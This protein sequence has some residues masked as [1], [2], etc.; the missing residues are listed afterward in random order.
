MAVLLKQASE[1]SNP[2]AALEACAILRKE[3]ETFSE[4][5]ILDYL[6]KIEGLKDEESNCMRCL[7]LEAY[8]V[9]NPE[10][11]LKKLSVLDKNQIPSGIDL[12]VDIIGKSSP[13]LLEK[14][15][16]SLNASAPSNRGWIH[17]VLNSLVKYSPDSAFAYATGI[18]D[19]GVR[20]STLA[21]IY[22]SLSVVDSDLA[23]TKAQALHKGFELDIAL[24]SIVDQLKTSKPDKAL[25]IINLMT[26][27]HGRED[28]L[29]ELFSQW[30]NSNYKC[31]GCQV[32]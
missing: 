5:E 19:S 4:S 25:E 17:S 24:G 32:G 10:M 28:K 8:A 27:S 29:G 21:W 23:L 9:L 11:V 30:A 26:N 7:L 3:I 13:E 18:K 22:S 6:A 12:I 16:S 31:Y 20:I 15:V 2:S 14:W 1:N